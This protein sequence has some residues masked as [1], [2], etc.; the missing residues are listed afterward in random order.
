[1]AEVV[2]LTNLLIETTRKA[3]NIE[4]LKKLTRGFQDGR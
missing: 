4:L 2:I 1:M 3:E